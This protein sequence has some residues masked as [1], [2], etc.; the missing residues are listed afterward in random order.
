M[1]FGMGLQHGG[2]ARPGAEG[3]DYANKFANNYE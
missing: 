3:E 1:F 2:P